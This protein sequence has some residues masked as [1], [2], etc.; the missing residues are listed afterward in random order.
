MTSR[1]NAISGWAGSYADAGDAAVSGWADSY[2][3][4]VSGYAE[5]YTD[6]AVT[7]AGGYTAWNI[8]DGT[9]AGDAI[10]NGE[11]V[12]ISGVSGITTDYSSNLL[13]ISAA[14]LS[15]WAGSYADAGDAAVS[16]WADSTMDTRDAAVSGWAQAYVDGQGYLTSVVE[17]TTPQLGGT[18]DANGNTINMG[19]NE[20][21]DTKVGQWDTAYGWA[22]HAS[23]GYLT[24]ETSHAD[25]LVD[26]DFS[27]QGI[28]LR[29]ASVGIYSILTDNSTNWNTA[30]GWGDHASAGYLSN[31]VEDTTPQLGGH[32]DCQSYHLS[33]V[34]LLELE[35]GFKTTLES[36]ADGSTVTFDLN[37]A[38]THTVTLG[39]NRALALSN[40]D[41]G[42]K[43]IIRLV[44]DGTGT[45]T[46]TWFSTI[47]WPG[48]LV[49]TLTTTGGK[50]D[51]FGFICTATNQ[52]DGYVIGYNL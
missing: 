3:Q 30:Y 21:T 29:G 2:I 36:N 4:A 13:R 12:Y 16:G 17:D 22:N 9:V 37:A 50:T 26:G 48:G 31:V 40:V 49:P 10:S 39:G 38:N 27:S 15:G 18:L 34:S 5:V 45:R 23:A 7:E 47:K 42:Q 24:S 1:D 20:I 44:Q 43:F 41:V 25:V 14:S 11:T 28:M 51:V 52:Y 8:S 33:G 35:G 46:V 6:A 19:S 32:L